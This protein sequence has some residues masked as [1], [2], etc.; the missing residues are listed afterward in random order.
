MRTP[1]LAAIPKLVFPWLVIFPGM[2]AA[3]F[4]SKISQPRFDYALPILMRHYYGYGLMGL[5]VSA[6]LASLMSGLAGNI[7]AFSTLCTHDLYQ[8]HLRPRMADAH[9]L[10]MGRFFTALAACLSVATAYIVLRYN[11][12]MDYLLLIFSLFSAPLFAVFLL[13]MFT[14]WATPTAGFW[15]LLCGLIASSLHGFAVRSG[16]ITYGSPLLGDFYGAIYAWAITAVVVTLVS[17][18]TQPKSAQDLHGI[19]YC[20]DHGAGPRISPLTWALAAAVLIACICLNVI[21]R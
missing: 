1:L 15:G 18:F 9:Y 16:I 4:L 2:A 7:T 6:I 14:R 13:G 8:T 11:N 12:L 17:R 19:T 20:T 10:R 21:F 5:G 3:I